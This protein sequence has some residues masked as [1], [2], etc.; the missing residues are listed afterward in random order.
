MPRFIRL[1]KI[2]YNEAEKEFEEDEIFI[3]K[4]H[5]VYIESKVIHL[6]DGTSF[7]SK[8]DYE[9]ITAKLTE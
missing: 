3:N 6:S 4:D 1:N 9:T 8:E 5:I 2:E 7:L